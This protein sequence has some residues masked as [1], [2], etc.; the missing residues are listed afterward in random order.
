[1]CG[2]SLMIERSWL[3]LLCNELG[4]IVLTHVPLLQ[5]SISWYWP[6]GADAQWLGR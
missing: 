1:M 4:Q 2:V 3:P 6:K 5:S